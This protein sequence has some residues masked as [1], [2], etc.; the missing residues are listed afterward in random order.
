MSRYRPY[1][2]KHV[3]GFEKLENLET[4]ADMEVTLQHDQTKQ[5]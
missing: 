5:T 3:E 2:Y 1:E 4:C